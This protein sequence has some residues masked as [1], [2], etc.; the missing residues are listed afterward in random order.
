LTRLN[1]CDVV[2]ASL[3]TGAEG[4][5]TLAVSVLAGGELAAS[6][7]GAGD[8]A[9]AAGAVV[10]A[11]ELG[12]GSGFSAAGLSELV[13]AVLAVDDFVDVL[14]AVERGAGVV[15]AAAAGVRRNSVAVLR[16]GAGVLTGL[17]SA[18]LG[19]GSGLA[20]AGAGA[21]SA[22]GVA[23][24]SDAATGLEAVCATGLGTT[25]SLSLTLRSNISA[26][27]TT[28]AVMTPKAIPKCFMGF[29]FVQSSR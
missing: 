8:E 3:V 26:P 6:V 25:I 24:G 2:A 17:A 15:G 28:E 12:A 22:G 13:F 14:E 5:A 23:A 27:T 21:T 7:E 11:V 20:I 18:T 10:D 16:R 4:G 1:H 9:T 19:A 29:S